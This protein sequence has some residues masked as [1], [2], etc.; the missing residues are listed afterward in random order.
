VN[1]KACC[2]ITNAQ[3]QGPRRDIKFRHL[4]FRHISTVL[5]RVVHRHGVCVSENFWMPYR[6]ADTLATAAVAA[7]AAASRHAHTISVS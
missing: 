7:A 2:V 5:R 4:G 1:W 6:L 3:T